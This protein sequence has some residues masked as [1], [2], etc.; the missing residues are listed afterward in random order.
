M[1]LRGVWATRSWWT[2]AL[3]LPDCRRRPPGP[4]V[5]R[6]EL[7]PTNGCST[8]WAATCELHGD[9]VVKR[10]LPEFVNP[11]ESRVLRAVAGVPGFAQEHYRYVDPG[12]RAVCSV[13]RRYPGDMVMEA[14]ER[15]RLP[16]GCVR[17][18]ARTLSACLTHLHTELGVAHLDLKPENVLC[19][20][21]GDRAV[22]CD[23]G[24]AHVLPA[25]GAEGRTRYTVGTPRYIAPELELGERF[26]AA[27]DVFSLGATLYTLL[28]ARR[29][30]ERLPQPHALE[31]HMR[32]ALPGHA[33]QR[34]RHFVRGVA[35][36]MAEDP[37]DRPTH[38]SVC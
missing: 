5:L 26:T 4:P 17:S 35:R 15:G 34:D 30:P 32:V 9:V 25:R 6:A 10:V 22:L 23:F 1:L 27:T 29:P 8:V 38:A 13:M 2:H 28:L 19:G 21:G 36:M 37:A 7:V 12:D 31:H 18:V 14:L 16:V 33:G 24:A 3:W 20:T 11:L